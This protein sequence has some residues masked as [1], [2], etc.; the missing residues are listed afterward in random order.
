MI[1]WNMFLLLAFFSMLGAAA[2]Q[3]AD[4]VVNR[5]L[6]IPLTQI[7]SNMAVFRLL[8][9]GLKSGIC[10]V[11]L[12]STSN[13]AD[14]HHLTPLLE[15]LEFHTRVS[16]P[17]IR[18]NDHEV[19][20]PLS[21][22]LEELAVNELWISTKNGESIADNVRAVYHYSFPVFVGADECW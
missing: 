16:A 10:G 3:H 17:K 9:P 12:F 15:R 18:A 22:P 19:H 11:K 13:H 6:K 1:R 8:D 14:F 7:E 21:D 4:Y 5:H 20:F 2:S